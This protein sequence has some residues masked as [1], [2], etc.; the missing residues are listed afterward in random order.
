LKYKN[1]FSA[2]AKNGFALA[3]AV[4]IK[5]PQA[6]FQIGAIKDYPLVPGAVKPS[7]NGQAGGTSVLLNQSP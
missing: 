2:L 5:R 7:V 1:P 6:D 4:F 3:L